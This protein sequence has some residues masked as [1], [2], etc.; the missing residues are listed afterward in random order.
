[1][2]NYSFK[3]P[4]IN[5]WKKKKKK[6]INSFWQFSLKVG[7]VIKNDDQSFKLFLKWT[8]L[9]GYLLKFTQLLNWLG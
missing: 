6:Y 9:V 3:V 8:P 4:V 1:M 7:I 2:V 5:F